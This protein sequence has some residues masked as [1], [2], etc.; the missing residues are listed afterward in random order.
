MFELLILSSACSQMWMMVSAKCLCYRN[1]VFGTGLM[2][3][4]NIIADPRV[5]VLS[6]YHHDE[7]S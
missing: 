4:C 3:T 6:N 1:M 5:C 7:F 2:G